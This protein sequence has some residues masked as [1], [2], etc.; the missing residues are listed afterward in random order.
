VRRNIYH[1]RFF[2]KGSGLARRRLL[3]YS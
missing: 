1:S 3:S 2:L